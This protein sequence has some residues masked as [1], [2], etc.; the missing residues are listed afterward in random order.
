VFLLNPAGL[1]GALLAGSHGKRS[2]GRFI[3]GSIVSAL[4]QSYGY[5]AFVAFIVTWT[6]LAAKREDVVG[7]L[8]WPVAFFFVLIPIR[9]TLIRARGEARERK[10]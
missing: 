8:L 2:E 10:S 1:P 9:L 3:F 5:L 4:G 7:L 6:M